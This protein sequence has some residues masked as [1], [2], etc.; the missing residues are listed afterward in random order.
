MIELGGVDYQDSAVGHL[1]EQLTE[2]GV[3][4]HRETGTACWRLELPESGDDYLRL[5]SK[6]RRERVRQIIR[7]KFDAGKA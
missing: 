4:V 1:V 3:L 7:R 5:L 6:S 2:R